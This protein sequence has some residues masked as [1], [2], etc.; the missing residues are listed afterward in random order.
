MSE[1][2]NISYLIE[3]KIIFTPATQCLARVDQP[4]LQIKL[5]HSASLCLLLLIQNHGKVVSQNELLEFGWGENHRQASFNAFYQSILSLRKSL[6]QLELEASFI[7]TITR[8]GLIIQDTF[9]IEEIDTPENCPAAIE[10][11]W[12][13]NTDLTEFSDNTAHKTPITRTES[14]LV[15]LTIIIC[16][17]ILYPWNTR[18]NYFS[19]YIATQNTHSNCKYYFNNDASDFSRHTAFIDKNPGL[20]Q[21]NK[22]IYITT[23]PESKK[24]SVIQCRSPINGEQKKNTCQSVY[25]PRYDS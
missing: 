10:E 17:L 19:G 25:Y 9:S 3:R 16:G 15:L 1:T 5:K 13:P 20:C 7:T 24:L 2:G 8:K 18:D 12:P 23:Y 4:E 21:D 6:L 22:F 14:V 11:D